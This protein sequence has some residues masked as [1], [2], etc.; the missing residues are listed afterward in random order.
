[1]RNAALAH[2]E[3]MSEPAPRVLFKKI[4]DATIEFDLICFVD[5]IETAGRVQSDLYF[6]VY[7]ALRQAGIGVP[8][9]TPAPITVQGL[10]KVEEQLE[11]IA[12]AIEE[13]HPDDGARKAQNPVVPV[14]LPVLQGRIQ[15]KSRKPKGKPSS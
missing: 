8:P 1:M 14:P 13:G 2:R 9:A 11:H 4:A 10:G 3:V 12:D 15:S 6:A 5:E 7:R